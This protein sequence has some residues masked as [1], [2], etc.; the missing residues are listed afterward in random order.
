MPP[1][2]SR[3]GRGTVLSLVALGAA[4]SLAIVGCGKSADQQNTSST[5]APESSPPATSQT[6]TTP[7]ADQGDTSHEAMVTLG[8]QVYQQR[9]ALC[10]G[11]AGKGNGPAAA[12][13]NP[14]PRDHTDAAYMNSRTDAQLLDVIHNGKGNMPAWKNVLTEREMRAVLI[15]VRS[16]AGK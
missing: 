16:L 15:H 14:K 8:N 13:L 7:A 9:C 2:Q 11:P 4:L 12:G 3:P 1:T 5:A 10:H 6:A